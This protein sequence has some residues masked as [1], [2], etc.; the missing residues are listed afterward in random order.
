MS[1]PVHQTLISKV[2]KSLLAQLPFPNFD[3]VG[4]CEVMGSQTKL[5]L[6]PLEPD[7]QLLYQES[8]SSRSVPVLTLQVSFSQTYDDLL[9]VTRR[10]IEETRKVQATILINVKESPSYDNPLRGTTKATYRNRD[11]GKNESIG[12]IVERMQ[13]RAQDDE[14]RSEIRREIPDDLQSPLRFRGVR[15][16]GRLHMELEI[17]ARDSETGKAT[18]RVDPIV[19]A[20][21]SEYRRS[22][23]H[24]RCHTDC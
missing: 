2:S 23:Y 18:R 19:S 8:E 12:T 11:T 16:V 24:C 10:T 20:S 13:L 21:E 6:F 17:W 9:L 14:L 15:W 22:T 7:M 3:A 4:S 1:T 5:N